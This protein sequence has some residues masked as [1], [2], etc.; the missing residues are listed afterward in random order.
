VNKSAFL[1]RDVVKSVVDILRP[2]IERYMRTEIHRKTAWVVVLD[3][4]VPLCDD[5]TILWEGAI[6]DGNSENWKRPYG[7]FA[8]LKAK[9]TWRTRLPSHLVRQDMAHL[10]MDGDIAYGGSTIYREIIVAVS[11]LAWQDD[12]MIAGAVASMCYAQVLGVAE[13]AIQDRPFICETPVVEFSSEPV[14]RRK[15][16]SGLVRVAQVVR[17]RTGKR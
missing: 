4:A 6:G 1:T 12:L 10:Y 8:R 2:G 7:K 5:M 17:R 15:S 16:K 14:L 3:P 9:L 11:G 13:E